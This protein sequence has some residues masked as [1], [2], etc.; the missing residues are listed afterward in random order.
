MNNRCRQIEKK[1]RRNNDGIQF[2]NNTLPN[3]VW[4]SLLIA[5]L[6]AGLISIFIGAFNY[7]FC[8]IDQKIP[9]Y[10]VIS[11]ILLISNA[12]V[13]LF[14]YILQHTKSNLQRVSSKPSLP[15]YAIEGIIIILILINVILGCMWVYGA[16]RYVHHE[17]Y[18][19]FLISSYC[20]HTL[21][22]VSWWSVTLHLIIFSLMIPY[23]IYN[24]IAS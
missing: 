9:L 16:M 19:S 13:R 10:L 11:G 5:Q 3:I 4:I 12:T 2:S 7:S 17:S 18:Q 15:Q 20:N 24:A 23:L 8:Y 21:Y 22:W 1:Q 14:T 6:F